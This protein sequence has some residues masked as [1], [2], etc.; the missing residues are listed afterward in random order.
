MYKIVA[1]SVEI[2]FK[3]KKEKYWPSWQGDRKQRIKTDLGKPSCT[4]A[5]K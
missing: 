3:S 4:P 5:Y 1:N 2:V